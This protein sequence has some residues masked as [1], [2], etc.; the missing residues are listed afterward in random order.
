MKS[1]FLISILTTLALPAPASGQDPDLTREIQQSQRRLEQI[2]EERSRLQRDLGD[3]QNRVRD[4]AAEL[5]NL[6]RRLSAT[7]SAL[8]EVEFQSDA[9]TEQ[10]TGATRDLVMSQEQL[11][12]SKAILIRRLRDIYKLSLIHI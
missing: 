9:T 4:A 5:G 8:A 6:E 2:R 12:M 7:R 3:V 10:V 1:W 11:A